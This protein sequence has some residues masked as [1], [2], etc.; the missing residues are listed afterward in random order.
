MTYVVRTEIIRGRL[1]A[2]YAHEEDGSLWW[3][4]FDGTDWTE[5]FAML[6]YGTKVATF[7]TLEQAQEYAEDLFEES[8]TPVSELA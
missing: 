4:K 8:G 2:A 1:S 6:G 5:F 7:N 3:W